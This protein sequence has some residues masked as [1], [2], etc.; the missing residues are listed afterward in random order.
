MAAVAL[1]GRPGVAAGLIGLA[2]LAAR[3]GSLLDLQFAVNGPLTVRPELYLPDR[4]LDR[5]AMAAGFWL[6]VAGTCSPM[7]AGVLAWRAVPGPH[8]TQQPERN[9]GGA[10]SCRFSPSPLRSAC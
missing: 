9:A 7:A 5:T 10:C 4:F 8:V 1:R 6:L 3:G 2:A